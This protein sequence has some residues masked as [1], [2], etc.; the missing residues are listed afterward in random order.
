MSSS[1]RSSSIQHKYNPLDRISDPILALDEDHRF[2]YINQKAADF[3]DLDPDLLLGE[4]VRDTL[5]ELWKTQTDTA[6]NEAIETDRTGSFEGYNAEAE[7]WFEYKIDSDETGVTVRFSD[8]TE[9][10]ERE[11]ESDRAETLFQNTQ[12]GLFVVDVEDG[13]ETFRLNRVNQSYEALT[14]ASSDEL[15]GK[16][17]REIVTEAD[18]EAVRGRYRECVTERTELTYEEQVSV[19]GDDAWWETRIAPVVIEG[20]VTQ[21]VGSTRKITERKEREKE[22]RQKTRAIDK[23]PVGITIADPSL[24]D[25]ALTYV[26]ERYS[27]VTGYDEDE[28]VGRNCRFLQGERTAAEPVTKLRDAVDRVEPTEVAL[29]NY[30]KDGTEFWNQLSIAPVRDGDDELDCFVGFQKDITEQKER[31]RRLQTHRLVVQAMNEAAFL[32]DDKK[33]IRFA[34]KAA[35]DFADA[36]PAELVGHPL[37][38]IAEEMAAPTEDPTRFVQALDSVL[39]DEE[40]SVGAWIRE[41]DGTKTLSLEFDLSLEAVGI[42]CAEQRFV[43]VELYDG[44]KGVAVISR[45]ITKRK[46]R[47]EEIQQHLVQAQE[48]GNVG[49]WHLDIEDESL[50][51]SDECYRIF[52][53]PQDQPITYERFL[54][55][56]HPEDRELV[57][58]AWAEALEGATYDIEHRILVDGKIK[59]LHETAEVKF[60]E[61]GEPVSGNG[62]VRDITGRIERERKINEQRRRYESLFNSIRDPIVVTDTEG[63]IRN[64]NPGF[65]ELFGYELDDV[66]KQAVDMLLADDNRTTTP[67]RRADTATEN[68]RKRITSEYKKRCGQEFPGEMSQSRFTDAD[69]NVIG[70]IYQIRDVSDREKNRQQMKVI[71]RVLRHNIRNDMTVIKG[72]AELIEA[73][74]LSEIQP[75][76]GRILDVS[77]KFVDTAEKQ[78]KITEMLTEPPTQTTLD[79]VGV[80]N[81]AVTDIQE[82]YPA[83]DVNTVLPEELHVR[84]IHEVIEALRELL[85]NAVIHSD[86]A[87]PTIDIDIRAEG[88]TAAISIVDDGPGIPEMESNILTRQAEIDPLYHGS[89]LGLWLVHETVRR[90]DGQLSFERTDSEGSCVTV[91]LL[92]E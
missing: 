27:E 31:E 55:A 54:D 49:S 73:N 32:V 26:N 66:E 80:L 13:G 33:R 45:D 4:H 67:L 62:V 77:Q 25:E 41:P 9:R 65:T 5:P 7:R 89:G 15:K 72:H 19:F 60:S 61:D 21:L 10:K 44:T 87:S 1:D 69:G 83:A 16:T 75:S 79:I 50:N 58:E 28:A 63:R 2:S 76:V 24:E 20:E 74:A 43:P 51:W 64:C 40:S 57:N 90:S 47:E 52:D 56:V 86:K 29:R 91:H 36:S 46:E 53:I 81:A 8:I 68:G 23:A 11:A 92:I 42:V 70:F 71:D 14:G 12:D 35:L 48:I 22:L 82:Q 78:R 88:E 3:L 34:N 37:A 39:S 84:A 85:R 6:F 59:W 38:P 17:I 18:S 30:R